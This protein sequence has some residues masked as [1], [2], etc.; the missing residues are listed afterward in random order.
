MQ[1]SQKNVVKRIKQL[2]PECV[3]IH[4]ILHREATVTKKLKLNAVVVGGQENELNNVLREVDDIVNSIRKSAKEQRLFSKLC[5]EMGS[6]CKKLILYSEVRRLSL[7]KVLFRVFELREQ[8]KAY[9][10]EQGNQKAAK[11]RDILWLAKLAYLA[12]IFDRLNEVNLSLQGKG[13]DIFRA[14][15][16]INA[17]KLKISLWKNNV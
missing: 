2:S 17:L 15:S 7:G 11:F 12:S 6:T 4:C 1:G 3:G 16:K 8:L 13:G 5:N 14:T 10:T 9:C